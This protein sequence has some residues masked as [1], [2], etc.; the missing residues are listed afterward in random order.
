MYAL[1]EATTS[2]CL[3][4]GRNKQSDG[5]KKRAGLIYPTEEGCSDCRYTQEETQGFA[6]DEMI[7]IFLIFQ[8]F[9]EYFLASTAQSSTVCCRYDI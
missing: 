7:I 8:P 5:E 4:E 1:G 2:H 3:L 6:T 9:L